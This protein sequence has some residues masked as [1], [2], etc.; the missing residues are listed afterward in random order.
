MMMD[1]LILKVDVMLRLS[2]LI[3][4][5]NLKFMIRLD[6]D[7]LL[8]IVVSILIQDR[9]ISTMFLSHLTLELPS[10]CNSL[11]MF[12][13][14]LMDL[15]HLISSFWPVILREYC[16]QLL[17][18]QVN[19]LIISS[20]QDILL[21]WV[22]LIWLLLLEFLNRLFLHV[23]VRFSCLCILLHMLRCSMKRLRSIMLKFGLL[24]LGK[25]ILIYRWTQGKY[26][27]GHR[28]ALQDSEKILDAINSGKLD[29][30]PTETF[31]Y[32]NF[33]VPTKV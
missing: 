27:D 32:F 1:Y 8:R 17:D 33:Q 29:N 30:V 14:Q 9:S 3:E 22:E 28:I 25:Y 13:F 2:I 20:C 6:M 5:L 15:I 21:K 10:H 24:I 12:I 23:L 26:G 7:L 31:K 18:Y 4:M 19:K 16:H 11:R